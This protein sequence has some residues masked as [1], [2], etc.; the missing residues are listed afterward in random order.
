LKK[1]RKTAK[2]HLGQLKNKIQNSGPQYLVHKTDYSDFENIHFCFLNFGFKGTYDSKVMSFPEKGRKTCCVLAIYVSFVDDIDND[3]IDY[4]CITDK[5]ILLI[6]WKF[7]TEYL[8]N[9]SLLKTKIKKLE[10]TEIIEQHHN[11]K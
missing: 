11:S 7:P 1:Y 3:Y 2:F 5:K 6:F 8:S 10:P 9:S 4:N